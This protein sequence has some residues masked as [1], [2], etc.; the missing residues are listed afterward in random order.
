MFQRELTLENVAGVRVPQDGVA[1]ARNYLAG[2]EG[3]LCVLGEKLFCG[4]LPLQVL[5]HLEQPAQA[6]LVR[7]AVQGSRESAETRGPGIVRVAQRGAHQVGRMRGDVA[8]LVVRVQHQVQAGHLLEL[9]AAVDAQHVCVVGRPVHALV[10]CWSSAVLESTA[11]D[12]GCHHGDLGN[13]VQCILKRV[14]PVLGLLHSLVVRGGEFRV[15]LHGQHAHRQLGHRVRFLGYGVQR[16]HHVGGHGA[17]V[18]KLERERLCLGIGRHLARQQQPERSLWQRARPAR[19]LWEGPVD[20]VQ[21][22]API[23]D[24]VVRVQIGGVGD[25]R[26]HGPRAVDRHLDGDH[27]DLRFAMV[28]EEV[29]FQCRLLLRQ[30]CDLSFQRR[31]DGRL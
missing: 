24:A 10:V 12:G 7:Q 19:R 5:L 20:V 1:E 28:L 26:L 27:L 3:V 8:P 11:V 18:V 29:V 25:H 6:L 14:L 31:Q 15:L 4:S 22:H 30:G 13:Q 9:L 23:A 21:G 2:G 16:G 17:P